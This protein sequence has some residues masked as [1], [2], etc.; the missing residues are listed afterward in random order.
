MVLGIAP[1]DIV[2]QK[3]LERF[4]ADDIDAQ[5]PEKA[6]LSVRG[7]EK[8]AGLG[9]RA[10]GAG[11]GRPARDGRKGFAFIGSQHHP[12]IGGQYWYVDLLLYHRRL[13]CHVAV[14][15]KI[16]AFQPE[17]AGTMN[18][19]PAALGDGERQLGDGT[20][21]GLILRRERNRVVVDLAEALPSAGAT[22]GVGRPLATRC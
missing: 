5:A 11:Q 13:R 7:T 12:E 10:A 15:L 18:F 20:S 1:Q 14:D 8:G 17:H 21:I 2:A 6:S 19:Y 9:T 4:S 22:R 16:G 3:Q